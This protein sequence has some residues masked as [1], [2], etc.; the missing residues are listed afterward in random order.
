MNDLIAL[1]LYST[2]VLIYIIVYSTAFKFK[3]LRLTSQ[4]DLSHANLYNLLLSVH[5]NQYLSNLHRGLE[6]GFQY[7]LFYL[8]KESQSIM[9]KQEK[10]K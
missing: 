2:K 3:L 8:K 6:K 5:Q 10:V 4:A 1:R 7:Q 9:L